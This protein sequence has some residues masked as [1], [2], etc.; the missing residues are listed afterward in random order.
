MSFLTKVQKIHGDTYKYSK[1]VNMM[2]PMEIHCDMGHTFVLTP[3][4]L[5]NHAKG[6]PECAVMS[7][8]R[9]TYEIEDE[10]FD[11]LFNDDTTSETGYSDPEEAVH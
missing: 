1:F 10:K 4:Q 8:E 3:N 2:F 6:C 7:V 11:E 9:V 5:I